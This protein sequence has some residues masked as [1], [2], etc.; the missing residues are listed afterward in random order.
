MKKIICAFLGILLMGTAF[1]QENAEKN[2]NTESIKPR[3]TFLLDSG[4]MKN[5]NTISTLSMQL[6]DVEKLDLYRA[7]QKNSVLPVLVNVFAGFGIGSYISGDK[8]GGII[9]TCL[10]A[11]TLLT[12]FILLGNY[13]NKMAEYEIDLAYYNSEKALHPNTSARM[14]SE[15]SSI[16]E[17]FSLI[18]LA[19][20]RTYQG[21]RANSYVKDYNKTLVNA[22][23]L[24]D[25][26]TS[27]LPTIDSNGNLAM[28]FNINLML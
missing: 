8:K 7:Y 9:G 13:M 18:L 17:L 26:R 5:Q 10:D 14:P 19:G 3:V 6:T 12:F 16:F 25:F 11:S 15:P 4:L 2:L 23:G 28:T 24:N 1:C 22:L 20:S 21:I 27:L